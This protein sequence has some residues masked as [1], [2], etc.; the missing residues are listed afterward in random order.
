MQRLLATNLGTV[1]AKSG[2]RLSLVDTKNLSGALANVALETLGLAL[3]RDAGA[4]KTARV[5]PPKAPPAAK[6]TKPGTKAAKAAKPQAKAAKAVAMRPRRAAPVHTTAGREAMRQSKLVYHARRR[7]LQALPKHAATRDADIA[8]IAAY[9]AAAYE[10][11]ARAAPPAPTPPTAP[12]EGVVAAPTP[13]TPNAPAT[14]PDG[15]PLALTTDESNALEGLSVI[16][17]VH[18]AAPAAPLEL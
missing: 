18:P 9:E 12:T 14:E 2:L 13:T 17:G 15:D 10:A 11:A 16:N 1:L 7:V 8:L 3:R 4:V 5:A 6:A